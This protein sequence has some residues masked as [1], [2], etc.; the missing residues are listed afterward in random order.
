M[1]DTWTNGVEQATSHTPS[2]TCSQELKAS[3]CSEGGEVEEKPRTVSPT[4]TLDRLRLQM[5]IISCEILEPGD[6][7]RPGQ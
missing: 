4:L 7:Y 6:F 1:Q 2:L 5:R 3:G